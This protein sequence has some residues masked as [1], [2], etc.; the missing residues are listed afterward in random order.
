MTIPDGDSEKVDTVIHLEK[1]DTSSPE[2][3]DT[4]LR[5]QVRD[6]N[7][8][9]FR[10]LD[11]PVS[12][13]EEGRVRWKIDR[14]LPPFLFLL[15]VTSWLD[16]SNLGN[17]ALMGIEKSLGLSSAT[18]SLAV[19]V[20]FVGTF[21]GDLGTNFGMRFMRPSR[22]IALAMIIWAVIAT[23][24]AAT[25]NTSGII[26]LRYFLGIFEAAVI[27]GAPYIVTFWYPREEWGRRICVYLSATSFAGAFGGWIVS[28][29]PE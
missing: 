14:R 20:F 28:L 24:M 1:T 12:P 15:Y 10:Q 13:E 22:Y 8:H 5:A 17:A 29:S 7:V 6:P 3:L 18:F 21:C 4:K 25:F 23:L 19:S 26:A 2:E 27:C 11:P 16:R 9:A